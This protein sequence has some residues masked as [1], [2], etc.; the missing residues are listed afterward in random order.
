MRATFNPGITAE[1][2]R[3]R[4]EATAEADQSAFVQAITDEAYQSLAASRVMELRG[5]GDIFQKSG[6]AFAGTADLAGLAALATGRAF[7]TPNTPTT[8]VEPEVKPVKEN[9]QDP[10]LQRRNVR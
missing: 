5:F 10:R 1:V 8:A 3:I 9:P 4:A 7:Q 6:G 2:S